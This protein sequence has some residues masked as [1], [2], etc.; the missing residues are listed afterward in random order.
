M[1]LYKVRDM[2]II[3]GTS[4]QFIRRYCKEGKIPEAI[5]T[6]RGW[7]IPEGTPKPGAPAKPETPQ[8]PLV[9]KILYQRGQTLSVQKCELT[10]FTMIAMKSDTVGF[11]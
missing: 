3:W 5:M 9:K 7:M 8:T 4:E 10:S 1:K 11:R 6:E 2:A